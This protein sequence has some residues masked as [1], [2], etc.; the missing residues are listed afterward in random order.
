MERT[1]RDH[2]LFADDN[3]SVDQWVERDRAPEMLG[4][5]ILVMTFAAGIVFGATMAW[6]LGLV[7]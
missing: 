1:E 7:T 6:V 5:A 3:R 4:I 2:W